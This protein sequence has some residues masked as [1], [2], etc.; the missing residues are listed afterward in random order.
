MKKKYSLI[1]FF[2]IM[3]L[4]ACKSNEFFKETLSVNDVHCFDV[5]GDSDSDIENSGV[6]ISSDDC[7]DEFTDSNEVTVKELSIKD[8]FVDVLGKEPVDFYYYDEY[9]D[10]FD[11]Y[12]SIAYN[13]GKYDSSVY[14]LTY[15]DQD[16]IP[17]L[18]IRWNNFTVWTWDGYAK[19]QFIGERMAYCEYSGKILTTEKDMDGNKRIIGYI[20][21]KDSMTEEISINEDSEGEYEIL[22]LSLNQNSYDII[23]N[24]IDLENIIYL[25]YDNCY[26]QVEILSVM[27]TGHDSSYTH[28]YEV[29][30]EDVTWEEAQEICN[31]K[32]GYLAVITSQEELNR[33]KG[34]FSGREEIA[35]CYIGCKGTYSDNSIRWYLKNGNT[36]EIEGGH[37]Y[38]FS[39]DTKCGVYCVEFDYEN[40]LMDYGFL[41]Y[42]KIRNDDIDYDVEMLMGPSDIAKSNP[43][44]SGKV[45]FICEYDE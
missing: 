45:G 3:L 29:I 9:N 33:I 4:T 11:M 10:W 27:K 40:E 19:N 26:S 32:G 12:S 2:V 37:I 28:S 6:N 43:E 8:E 34:L 36:V 30:Y 14:Y 20:Y 13:L 38:V 24:F 22:G 17:E 1:L 15:I 5:E 25:S 16:E 42:G 23:K 35:V 21:N 7:S 18:V 44:L 41:V 39:Y 31:E